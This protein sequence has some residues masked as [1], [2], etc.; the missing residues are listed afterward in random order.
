MCAGPG[1]FRDEAVDVKAWMAVNL[2]RDVLPGFKTVEVLWV[3]RD[4]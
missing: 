2:N 4:V 3:E 1:V